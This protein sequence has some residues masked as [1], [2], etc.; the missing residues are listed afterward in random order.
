MTRHDVHAG[1]VA[2]TATALTLPLLLAHAGP[3][4]TWQAMLVVA[5]LGLVVVFV[6]TLVGVVILDAPADLVLPLASVAIAS[7]L[8]PIGSAVLSDWVGWAFPIGVVM[9]VALLVTALTPLELRWNEPLAF[10]AVAIAAIGAWFLYLPIT[11]A[12]HPPAEFLPDVDDLVLTIVAPADGTTVDA[13]EVV[14]VVRVEGGSIGAELVPAS[15]L[16]PGADPE[17]AGV[18]AA[19]VDGREVPVEI[20]ED[21]SRAAP[22]TTVSFPVDLDPGEHRI[23]VEFRRMDGAAFTPIVIERTEVTAS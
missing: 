21:C 8:S 3:G 10:G 9:L 4:A 12:W 23:V 1:R 7:S 17:E 20:A 16:A 6:L 19:A 13:G 11:V 2:V 22:C 15:E 14:V 5:S 18:L